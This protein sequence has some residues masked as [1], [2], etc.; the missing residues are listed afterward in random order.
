MSLYDIYGCNRL[1]Y[2]LFYPRCG[3]ANIDPDSLFYTV[4]VENH[5]KFWQMHHGQTPSTIN[6]G[7]ITFPSFHV[8]WDAFDLYIHFNIYISLPFFGLYCYASVV[9]I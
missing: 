3:S 9:L 4:Q 5:L 6:G 1:Y 7:L 2:L 8:L